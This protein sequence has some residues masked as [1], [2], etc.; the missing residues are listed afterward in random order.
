M[1]RIVE[2][3]P[4]QVTEWSARDR[5]FTVE[6]E[7]KLHLVN[8]ILSYEAIA[9]VPY[10]KTY[11][12]WQKLS[13]ERRRNPPFER[14]ERL[15]SHREPDRCSGVSASRAGKNPRPTSHSMGRIK[16]FPRR[17]ARNPKQQRLSVS[18]LRVLWLQIA[19]LRFRPI[20]WA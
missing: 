10:E 3:P 5:T 4:G 7:L 18:T 1:N 16:A 14:L 6:R 17:H 19:G 2:V 9:I 15:R 12:P 11:P 13:A 8:G 20:S